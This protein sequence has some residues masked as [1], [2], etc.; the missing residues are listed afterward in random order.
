MKVLMQT[1]VWKFLTEVFSRSN[2]IFLLSIMKAALY[3]HVHNI[4]PLSMKW[5]TY[6][7]NIGENVLIN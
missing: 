6:W 7:Q 4:T 3:L 5:L 2:D 1:V